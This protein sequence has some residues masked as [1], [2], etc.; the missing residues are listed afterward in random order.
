MHCPVCKNI[1]TKVVDSRVVAAGLSVRRRRECEKCGERFTTIE[2]LELLDITVI[3]RDG[4]R[5]GYLREKIEQGVRAALRKR[6]Y[7][8]EAFHSLLSKVERDIQKKRQREITSKNIGDIVMHHLKTFDKVAY[9]RFASIYQSF[10][11]VA[12]FTREVKN[13]QNKKISK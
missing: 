13:L 1:D 11:D 5:E 12:T 7:T 8:G 2:E 3:K 4:R 9:I 6:P 10:A